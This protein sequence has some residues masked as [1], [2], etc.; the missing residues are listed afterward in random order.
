MRLLNRPPRRTFGADRVSRL[1]VELK[2]DRDKERHTPES[3]AEG[4]RLH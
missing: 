1:L 3:D 4:V 2:V